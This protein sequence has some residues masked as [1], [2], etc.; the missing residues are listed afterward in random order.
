MLI[1][2]TDRKDIDGT[3]GASWVVPRRECG[4]VGAVEGGESF[5]AIGRA[6]R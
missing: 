3:D 1:V 4:A 6:A 2:L 5:T